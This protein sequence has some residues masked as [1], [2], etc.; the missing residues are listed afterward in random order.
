MRLCNV[1][2]GAPLAPRSAPPGPPPFAR[3]PGPSA[4]PRRP[5]VLPERL[6][7]HECRTAR[8][9]DDV[10]R[11]AKCAARLDHTCPNTVYPQRANLSCCTLDTNVSNRGY[12][13]YILTLL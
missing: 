5:P 6:C 10:G 1:R 2:R 9:C 8:N 12:T 11:I 13:V 7:R 4:T 3:A